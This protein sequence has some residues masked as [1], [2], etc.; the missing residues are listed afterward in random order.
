[1]SPVHPQLHRRYDAMFALNNGALDSN[2]RHWFL[3][4]LAR[5]RSVIAPI[6]QIQSLTLGYQAHNTIWSAG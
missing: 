5:A 4:E 6:C 3:P 2:F 1:M